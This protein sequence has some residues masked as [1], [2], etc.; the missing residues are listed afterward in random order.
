MFSTT[1]LPSDLDFS[2]FNSGVIQAWSK[3]ET[4]D[5][6][7]RVQFSV[8]V[9]IYSVDDQMVPDEFSVGENMARIEARNNKTET[10]A[11][12]RILPTIR[13]KTPTKVIDEVRPPN[14][15]R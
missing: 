14:K 6:S 13:N 9:G 15:T 7:N 5:P 12:V 3:D 8:F 1:A 4:A 2:D 11:E 10:T